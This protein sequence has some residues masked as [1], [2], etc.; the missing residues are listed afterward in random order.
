MVNVRWFIVYCCIIR[1]EDVWVVFRK[2]EKCFIIVEKCFIYMLLIRLL[3]VNCKDKYFKEI[4]LLS[5]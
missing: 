1:L 2:W 3:M 4:I 5:I